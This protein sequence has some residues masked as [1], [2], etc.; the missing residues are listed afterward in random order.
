MTGCQS[1][2]SMRRV[3]GKPF[4]N[5]NCCLRPVAGTK[6]V[7]HPRRDFTIALHRL[8]D[9]AKLVC[10]SPDVRA[11]SPDD[12][13]PT[14]N[15]DRT[16]VCDVTD[17]ACLPW[18]REPIVRCGLRKT[19]AGKYAR[20]KEANQQQADDEHDAIDGRIT[21]HFFGTISFH[22]KSLDE[23]AKLTGGICE[24]PGSAR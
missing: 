22:E 13:G 7:L 21:F 5:H 12:K 19:Y 3:V 11:R 14:M 20:S 2:R 4:A 1:R 15:G 10:V 17:V 16:C 6:I 8:V 24:P 18:Q 9:I 23:P